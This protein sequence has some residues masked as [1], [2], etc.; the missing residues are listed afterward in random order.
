LR[1]SAAFSFAK[2]ISEEVM[3]KGNRSI[4][5]LSA[6]VV[7]AFLA[8]FA[9]SAS[10][11]PPEKTPANVAGSWSVHISGEVGTGEQTLNIVQQDVGIEGT[12]NGP[13]AQGKIEGTLDGNAIKFMLSGP[14]PLRYKGTVAGDT[15]GGTVT[16]GKDGKSGVWSARRTKKI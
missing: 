3:R 4:K 12:F 10:P 13:W 11:T 7:L 14:F 9:V 2:S 16:G 1:A 6:L 15:M 8:A 5:I